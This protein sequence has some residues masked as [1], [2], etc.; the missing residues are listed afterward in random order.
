MTQQKPY[1]SVLFTTAYLP[2]LAYFAAFFQAEQT[3]LESAEHYLKQSYRNRCLI[4]SAEGPK[5]LIIPIR[6]YTSEGALIRDIR[7]DYTQNW[8]AI[9]WKSL[10]T[11]Y[12]TSPFFLYYRDYL[13]SFYRKS[14]T[15]L[16]DF[17]L[18]LWNV[19]CSL[20]K[21][22]K[23]L[24][25]TQRYQKEYPSDCLDLRNS[26]H[27]KKPT[28]H[29]LTKDFPPYTQVFSDRCGFISNLSIIDLLC[30]KGNHSLDY[31]QGLANFIL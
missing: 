2:P 31:L 27:P 12:N 4:A 19:L 30:N 6:K 3:Y 11:S 15:F 16:W 29:V 10:E 25:F 18:D 26:L 21:I 8:Q 13:E 5:A 23:T 7:I 14:F 1:T 17:N 24:T 20:L 9:H 28:S 22:S